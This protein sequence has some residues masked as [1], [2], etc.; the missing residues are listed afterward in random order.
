M[1]VALSTAQWVVGKALAPVAD[2][3]LEAWGNSN[4]LGL[5]VEALGTELLLV[6]ATL[7]TASR[8]QIGGQAME[9]LL[10]K[11]RD[12]AHCAE[13]LL[14]ELDYFR[15]HDELHGT[16]DASDQ[17]A[18]GGVHDLALNARH[19]AKAVFGLSS[20]ATP[21]EP[22]QVIQDARQRIGC[23]AWPR[24]TQRSRGSSSSS[25]SNTNQADH[26]EVRGC[27]PKLGKL[28]L[29][30]SSP[31]DDSSGNQS[32]LRGA[33]QKERAEETPMPRFNRVDIS[34]RMKHIV[35]QLQP[36]RRDFINILQS[37]DRITVPNIAQSRPITTGRS[38][39]PKLY[40]R[41]HI[42]NSIIHDM[43]KGKYHSKDLTVLPIVG[44]GGIGKTT[45]IQ[46]I[47]HNKE[48]QN[49]FQVVIWVCVSLS[50]NLNKLL[51]DIKKDIPRVE[52]EKDGRA[53]E[54]IE[55][56][57]KS[58]R[59]LLVLDDIWECSNEDDWERLFLPL[60]KS[61]EKGSMIL[62][63]T[64]FSSIA[65]MVGTM[66]HS[67]ELRGIESKYFRELFYAFVFGDDQ[68]RR[69]DN[70]LLE[71]GDKIMVKLKGSPLAA[72][73]VGRLLRKDLNLRHWR[74]VLESKE[75]E[76]LI[77]ANDIM[78]AL[79]L[80]YD[81]LPFQLQQC[82]FYTALFPEDFHLSSSQLINL[83][84]GLDIL[85]PDAQNRSFEDIGLS[86]LNDLVGHGF[87]REEETD[88][89]LCYF[90]HD[91]LHDLALQ[92]ASHDCAS[93]HRS[94]VGLVQIQPSI[95]HLSII[96]DDVGADN[97][98]SPE[99]FKSQLTKLKTILKVKQLHTL[100]VFGEMDESFA[101]I[102]GDL[103]REANA[104]R[105]LRLVNMPSSVESIL[106]N[107]SG[108]LHLRYLCLGTKY[109]MEMHLPLA[110][111]RF[112]HLRILDLGSWY[113]CRDLPKDLSNL[114]KLRHF[115]T[116][117]DELHSEILN[118]GKLTLL[119]ELKVFRVNKESEGFELKQLEPLT[120]LRELG[121]YNLE[122]IHTKEEAANAKLIEKNYLERL[123]LVWDSEQQSITESDVE[124]VLESLQPH[125]YLQE[126]CIRGHRGPSCPTWLGDKL[127]VEALESVHLVGV[128][129]QCLPSLGKM[130][131]LVKVKLEHI[132]AIEEL[133]I[134]QSFCRLT[135]LELVGLGSFQKW[136]PSQDAHMFPLLQVLKIMDCP[137][138]LELPFS[139]N[140]VYPKP[141]QDWNIDWFPKLQE[142]E[143]WMCQEFLF[144]PRIP[145]TETLC[146][147]NIRGVKVL[148]MFEYSKSS[149]GL[150][151]VGKDDLQ[152]LDQVLAF[153]NLTRLEKL[154]LEKCPPL[155]P[156]HLLMLPSVKTLVVESS[157]GLAGPLGG[158][159]DVEWQH[160]VECLVVMKLHGDS[161]K[162][163]TELLT[164]LPRL[165][166]LIIEN[167]ENNHLLSA[168]SFSCCLFPSSLQDLRLNGV[169]GLG[170]LE[171]LSNLTNLTRL[172]LFHCGEDLRC[173]GLEP[174]LT[175]GGQL[176]ELEVRF[177]PRFFAGWDP[178]PRRVLQQ[179][180][181]GEEQL[182]SPL[183]SS[184]L[185]KLW[186]D[187]SM[188]LLAAPI[189][190]LLSSSLTELHLY[191]TYGEMKRF[192]KEQENALHLL[193]SL[194]QLQ[195][196]GFDEL[197]HLP[198][199][200]HKLTNL[201]R[202]EVCYCPGVWSLPKDGLPKSLQE[203]DVCSCSNKE[204]K[205]QC[206]ALVATIPKIIID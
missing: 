122:N 13:D 121:I 115:C 76:R 22:G 166:K 165:S 47:Y 144:M 176:R 194:Q 68:C 125:G 18:K 196:L 3:M 179:D 79:K 67:I 57:L 191:G 155:E 204:L 133:V 90:M 35:G 140:N 108:L 143:I 177:S 95:R 94:N 88:G 186:T 55:Q 132:A 113:R 25:T 152:S 124:G 75:W 83:W 202:L 65:K 32:T 154:T 206:R 20:A 172:D 102:L 185:Q 104:L 12:S 120:D 4:N 178:N 173:K 16:Y 159:C 175:A 33:P 85:Q 15:I 8:K 130:W 82:F 109:R 5:N 105:V 46:H 164:H 91:L 158:G 31:H 101:K 56:R 77:G 51:E 151:I 7:E 26:K 74:R 103:F 28:L 45:M 72:K 30:S 70:F 44:P 129:W 53:E 96:I 37:C 141:D 73:T 150:K 126:L 98:A 137:K 61:Q 2:G 138:L 182:V 23:C 162:E 200:L 60:R 97:A 66:D 43:T 136:V 63:T 170:T 49:H 78:P 110:I 156:K 134:E 106:L 112:Y 149:V 1:D 128:S 42:M 184:K 131:G 11:L 93:L 52:G 169:K 54:L 38:I 171:P 48:V 199:G 116:P 34:E 160:P 198:A 205:Q 92:V 187:D 24:A 189:C 99:N 114:A 190:S 195:F 119:E 80:S 201:K 87:F 111:S 181:G 64:R 41:D 174:L 81:Y 71:T 197:Q 192:T 40:G 62:V 180:G 117:N 14:D 17:H 100:M 139:N 58:K 84:I 59:L 157:D 193:D 123:T 89:R 127:N 36:V 148:D 163:L 27:M 161:G 142:L 145:W 135:R 69:D 203:L 86:I 188:G 107:F 50:F 39:E 167:C 9:K 118:V 19:T 6:K 146:H 168:G 153:K 147:V 10:W 183:S 21:A 29:C